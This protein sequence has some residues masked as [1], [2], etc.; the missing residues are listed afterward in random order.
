MQKE[1]KQVCFSVVVD[2]YLYQI[3]I[4]SKDQKAIPDFK[5]GKP[6]NKE[7]FYQDALWTNIILWS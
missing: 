2:K 5:F 7:D 1:I 3:S 6:S 4:A